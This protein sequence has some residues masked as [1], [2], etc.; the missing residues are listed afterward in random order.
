LGLDRCRQNVTLLIDPQSANS[1]PLAKSHRT[2]EIPVGFPQFCTR[3]TRPSV[4]YN[5]DRGYRKRTI[6]IVRPDQNQSR[7][8]DADLIII[9]I[10]GA[11]SLFRNIL[12]TSPFDPIFYVDQGRYPMGNYNRIKILR[13][14]EKK[15]R[16]YPSCTSPPDFR[17]VGTAAF[18]CPPR[19]ATG[20]RDPAPPPARISSTESA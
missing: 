16:G 17:N 1:G 14:E 15:M 2:R 13:K 9:C 8:R 6:E 19:A 10:C 18:G 4:T 7:V 20:G 11:N 5:L 12:P 3:K